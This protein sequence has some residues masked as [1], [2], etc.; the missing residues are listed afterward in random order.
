[1]ATYFTA[2]THFGHPHVLD[3]CKRPF[4]TIEQ[5]DQHLIDMLNI[6]VGRKDRLI[7]AGDFCHKDPQKYRMR[8]NVKEIIL[9][10]GNHD[11]RSWGQ[12]FSRAVETLEVKTSAHPIW[13]SHYPHAYWPGSHKGHGHVYGHVHDYR[14]IKLNALFPGRRAMDVG[15]DT[16]KRRLGEYR[17]FRMDAL[18][19]IFNSRPGHDPVDFYLRKQEARNY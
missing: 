9:V 19:S 18:V 1:M 8:I 16:A 11:K 2:D 17:P 14:E 15:V 12:I 6:H 13:V 10:Y 7:I 5:H 4:E 3:F